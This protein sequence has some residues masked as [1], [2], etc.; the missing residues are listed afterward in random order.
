MCSSDLVVNE[1]LTLTVVAEKLISTYKHGGIEPFDDIDEII[2]KCNT[3]AVFSMR[4]LLRVARILRSA[5]LTVK[6]FNEVP[7]EADMLKGIALGIFYD[8]KLEKEITTNIISENV[9]SD[10]ASHGNPEI[11]IYEFDI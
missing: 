3:G 7:A 10:N 8:E 6:S 9:M 5:R 2:D 4:E 11:K 1:S